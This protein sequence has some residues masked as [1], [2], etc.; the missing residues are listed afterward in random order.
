MINLLP[1][2]TS[3][4]LRASRHNSILMTYLIGASIVLG[5]IAMIYISIYI[6]MKT[7]EAQSI[8]S[9]AASKQRIAQLKQTEDEAKQYSNNLSTAKAI[10]ASQL[11]YTTALHKIAS[12]LPAGTVLE[13]LDLNSTTTA[14]PITLSIAAKT[15]EAALAIKGS[16]EKAGVAS[17]ITIVSLQSQQPSDDVPS[18]YPVQISLS[19]SLEKTLFT[20]ED[21]EATK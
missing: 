7:T 1:P 19:L 18:A 13:S 17:N 3:K 5:L 4:Q 10:F 12:A 6:M 20:S 8:A 16:L 21:K 2:Q 15:M 14:Q 11:S 9:S